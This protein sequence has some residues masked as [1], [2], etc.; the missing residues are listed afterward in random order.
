MLHEWGK[1][2]KQQYRMNSIVFNV[3]VTVQACYRPVNV[4]LV[5]P[6]PAS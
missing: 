3:W 1:E 4:V 6:I 5:G 2:E